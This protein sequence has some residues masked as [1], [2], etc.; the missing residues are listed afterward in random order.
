M[1]AS[2]ALLAPAHHVATCIIAPTRCNSAGLTDGS[3]EVYLGSF[4]RVR[5]V[6][7][8]HTVLRRWLPSLRLRCAAHP[9]WPSAAAARVRGVCCMLHATCFCCCRCMLHAAY[10]PARL[11]RPT[12]L[13][14]VPAHAHAFLHCASAMLCSSCHDD[15]M[16]GAV[17]KLG[18]PCFNACP[19]VSECSQCSGPVCCMLEVSA[20]A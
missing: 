5:A 12:A 10:L 11:A 8:V 17:A 3:A 2:L 6:E 1:R 18:S 4:A 16:M 19:Q 15:V 20:V 7:L 9:H 14:R 13:L